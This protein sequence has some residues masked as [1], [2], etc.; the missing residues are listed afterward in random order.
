M[1]VQ[2]AMCRKLEVVEF[3]AQTDFVAK[4][5]YDQ[6]N[7]V[8]VFIEKKRCSLNTLKLYEC[9]AKIL[10]Q[11]AKS[12]ERESLEELVIVKFN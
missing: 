8:K 1:C 9:D 2:L 7:H 6:L 3:A 11:L 12:R 5:P 10:E 4:V